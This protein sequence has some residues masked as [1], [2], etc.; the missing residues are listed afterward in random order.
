MTTPALRP[1]LTVREAA[2]IL[3][4]ATKTVYRRIDAGELP[5]GRIGTDPKAPIRV[6]AADLVRYLSPE[7]RANLSE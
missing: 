3:R 5:V 2:S 1:L 6:R 4:V 7:L